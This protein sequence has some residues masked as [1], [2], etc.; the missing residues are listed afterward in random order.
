RVLP[1]E[2]ALAD[3]DFEVIRDAVPT[4]DLL[5]ARPDRVV[6]PVPGELVA[7]DQTPRSCRGDDQPV[8][9]AVAGRQP[10]GACRF[11]TG[12]AEIIE[13]PLGIGRDS[14]VRLR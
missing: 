8:G 4:E 7:V 2:S 11:P 12:D 13:V 1:L 9:K 6:L 10:Q 3:G 14:V 5:Q